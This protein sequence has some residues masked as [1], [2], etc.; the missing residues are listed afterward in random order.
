MTADV[1][2]FVD[3]WQGRYE[4]GQ[5]SWD[6]QGPSPHLQAFAQDHPEVFQGKWLVPGAGR[7]HDA[8]FI[9][10][11]GAD[12]T[13]IDYA[14]GAVE[15]A[16]QLY[17]A[18]DYRQ[19]DI[20]NL[21]EA[22]NAKFDGVFEHTCFCAINPKRRPDYVAMATKVLKPGGVLLGVFWEH[23]D[24]DGPPFSTT[25]EELRSLFSQYFQAIHVSPVVQNTPGRTG[26]E[27]WV[28]MTHS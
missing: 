1:N 22:F 9:A 24:P 8:A 7:G 15:A 28:Q 17:P 18:L 6:L 27:Y 5:T 4:S 11:P 13:A 19:A 16:G 10:S 14:P 3:F 23:D 25:P 21:D 12:V 26:Q 20:F 2:Q